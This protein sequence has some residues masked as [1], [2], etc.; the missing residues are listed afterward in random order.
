MASFNNIVFAGS[1]AR[2]RSLHNPDLL[3]RQPIQLV[4]QDVDLPVRGLDLSLQGGL[5]VRRAGMGRA[6]SGYFS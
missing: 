4:D 2:L 5:F 3:F 1:F 6:V